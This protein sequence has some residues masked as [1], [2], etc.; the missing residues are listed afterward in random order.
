VT[1]KFAKYFI[2]AISALG[3]SALPALADTPCVNASLATYIADFSG[4]TGCTVTYSS[5]EELD[6]NFFS[7]TLV[8]LSASTVTV[9]PVTGGPGTD[10]P[11]LNFNPAILLLG[12]PAT[13]DIDVQFD[14]TVVTGGAI[15]DVYIDFGNVT[16]AGNGVVFYTEKFCDTS[17]TQPPGAPP[18]AG[19][20]EE[21]VEAPSAYSTNVVQLVNSGLGA[22]TNTLQINKD[23]TATTYGAGDIAGTSLFGNEY[24]SVPEPRAISL[25]LGLGLLAGIA[26]FKRRQATQS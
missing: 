14:A 26:I 11:G 17:Y 12:G 4:S 19:A 15:S 16:Q 6:F 10:G 5:G 7:D 21:Y 24:S 13:E 8:N 25:L 22:P 23:L 9:S 18:V 3:L 1:H 2:L 20:C